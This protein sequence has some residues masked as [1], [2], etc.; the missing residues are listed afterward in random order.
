VLLPV[1]PD[2]RW[3]LASDTTPW[4]AQTRLYRQTRRGDWTGPL[5]RIAQDL[6]AAPS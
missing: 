6:L 3:G 5:R 1:E 2:W 4:Y